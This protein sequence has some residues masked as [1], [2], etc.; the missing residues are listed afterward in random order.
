MENYKEFLRCVEEIVKILVDQVNGDS[1][2]KA[3]EFSESVLEPLKEEAAVTVVANAFANLDDRVKKALTA[4]LDFFNSRYGQSPTKKDAAAAACAA[5]TVKS[6]L[7][8]VLDL[9][10][11]LEKLLKILNELLSLLRA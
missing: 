6:S 1:K 3:T 7:E 8:E 2:I 11:W 10:D 9:P 5:E 4:E